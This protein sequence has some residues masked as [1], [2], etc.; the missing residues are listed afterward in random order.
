MGWMG[1]QKVFQ[2]EDIVVSSRQNA[3]NLD[4]L[5]QPTF[6]LTMFFSTFFPLV[7]ILCSSFV[8]MIFQRI[9]RHFYFRWNWRRITNILDTMEREER[10]L[11]HLD[12]ADS[13]GSLD[14]DEVIVFNYLMEQ[15]QFLGPSGI[16]SLL[17]HQKY[18]QLHA[19]VA[20]M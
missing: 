4:Y 7:L 11:G 5:R 16:E 15:Q 9:F 6:R 8:A 19:S 1:C 17:P 3:D 20:N 12:E 13:D 10:R 2:L 18:P 14:G